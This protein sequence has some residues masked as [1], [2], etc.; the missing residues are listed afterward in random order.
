LPP[1]LK[2]VLT[3]VSRINNKHNRKTVDDFTTFLLNSKEIGDKHRARFLNTII[4][5][6]IRL[7]PTAFAQVRKAEIKEFL[8]VRR[9]ENGVWERI[10][11]DPEG[12][13]V[14]TYNLRLAFCRRFI[15]WY[16]NRD[17]DDENDWETPE[18]L[19][20]KNEKAERLLKGPYTK[21]QVWTRD[22]V[23]SI[24]KYEPELRNKAL[25]TMSWDMYAR[26]H[27]VA[28]LRIK[29]INFGVSDVYADGEI[30][31]ETK[32]GGGEFVLGMSYPFAR[33]WHNQH[34]QNTDGNA[35]FFYSRR[36]RDP[37]KPL[38]SQSIRKIFVRLRSRIKRK[39]DNGSL[40]EE[41]QKQMIDLINRKAW[42]PYCMV[43][44]SP[45]T[46]AADHKPMTL[47]TKLARW[48]QNTR[49]A[50]RYI[51]NIIGQDARNEILEDAGI[52]VPDSKKSQPAVR[53]CIN[54]NYVNTYESEICKKCST[55]LTSIAFDRRRKADENKMSKMV[56]PMID[57][58]TQEL[59][60]ELED[61]YRDQLEE[62]RIAWEN[63]Q[64]EI[65][66]LKESRTP[67]KESDY[68]VTPQE[69]QKLQRMLKKLEQMKEDW[70]ID[71]DEDN[72]EVRSLA[73]P[74]S[75]S[76]Q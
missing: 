65:A 67:P 5:F 51:K 54:C 35:Y 53:Q 69:L 24:L 63:A 73:R 48:S 26:N 20:I 49:Q 13:W 76:P 2:A 52:K 36:T 12:R 42:N 14:S 23:L 45:L 30:P 40:S 8:N 50:Q 66:Y 17:K 22:E 10:I 71:D 75:E 16:Y 43:R 60:K 59:K 58:K 15:R 41:E 34:P 33:D 1:E 6:G 55:P 39:V 62:F 38:E 31:P 19:K 27:E 3:R 28:S 7:G 37:Y 18:W 32:T 70:G 47:I 4:E 57:T 9:T 25:I 74:S 21:S 56:Q 46:Y 29:E 64:Q 44:H 11:N 61:K 72:I 68:K